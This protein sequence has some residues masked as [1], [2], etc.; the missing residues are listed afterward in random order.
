MG[1]KKRSCYDGHPAADAEYKSELDGITGVQETIKQESSGYKGQLAI[2]EGRQQLAEEHSGKKL[3]QLRTVEDPL[4]AS[5]EDPTGRA[6]GALE[7]GT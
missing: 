6:Q 2:S 1:S 5:F 3:N 4:N 7:I